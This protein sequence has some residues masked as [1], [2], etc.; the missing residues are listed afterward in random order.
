[1]L[2]LLALFQ[3][4]NKMYQRVTSFPNIFFA[5]ALQTNAYSAIRRQKYPDQKTVLDARG[6]T[7]PDKADT[8]ISN[9]IVSWG[10]KKSLSGVFCKSNWSHRSFLIALLPCETLQIALLPDQQESST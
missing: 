2:T 1:M 3:H 5:A 4:D 7:R 8:Y 10:S 9:A 6:Q